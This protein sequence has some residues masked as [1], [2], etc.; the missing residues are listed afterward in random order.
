MTLTVGRVKV[1]SRSIS[2]CDCPVG[3]SRGADPKCLN[4]RQQK[5]GKPI[6]SRYFSD[7]QGL[8]R[9]PNGLIKES[10][11]DRVRNGVRTRVERLFARN[12]SG[13]MV[14]QYAGTALWGGLIVRLNLQP[15]WLI[16]PQYLLQLDPADAE[17]LARA[18][19]WLADCTWVEFLDACS[20][21]FYI[22]EK[23][24]HSPASQNVKVANEFQN[25]LNQLF[26]RYYS[27]Y[28]MDE[29]G[30]IRE[31][32]TAQLEAVVTEARALLRGKAF[33][34]P[35]RRFQSALQALQR[36]P[37]A[38]FEG[39]VSNAANAMEGTAKAV[40]NDEKVGFGSAIDRI[41]QSNKLNGALAK[42]LKSLFGYA[43]N[44]GGRHGI[45]GAPKVDR[46]IAEFYVHQAAAAIIL[47]ARM[48]GYDDQVTTNRNP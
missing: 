39:A 35:D 32:G 11:P 45:V 10:I 6:S 38:D 14:E 19:G 5:D 25:E 24:P 30:L 47:L 29:T 33:S 4:S 13:L 48:Y 16:R 9:P 17:N 43:S 34:G 8:Y 23:K 15:N 31:E 1:R 21:I 7:D 46:A 40:L 26:R 2:L 44:E 12:P 22:L 28:V 41:S 20:A 27:A 3:V 42:S 37:E 18:S 36:R